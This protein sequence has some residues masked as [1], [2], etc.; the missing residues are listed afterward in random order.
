MSSTTEIWTVTKMF[1]GDFSVLAAAQISLTTFQFIKIEG[2]VDICR[3][4]NST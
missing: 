2:N 4:E 1:S 3:Y